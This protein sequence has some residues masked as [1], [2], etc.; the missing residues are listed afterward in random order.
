MFHGPLTEDPPVAG[1][2]AS[3]SAGGRRVVAF[4]T[5]GAAMAG[6]EFNA[7]RLAEHLDRSRWQIVLICPEEGDL[8]D[9]FRRAGL[10]VHVLPRRRMLSSSIR[11]GSHWRIP[12][13]FACAWDIGVIMSAA[14]SL[15][16][17]LANE[18]R[19]ELV[20]TKGMF[21]H[22]YGALAARRCGV[23]CLWHGEDFIS[24]RW[25]GL[26]RRGFGAAARRL[27]AAIAVIG[28]PIARQLPADMQDR[29]RVIHN[30]GDTH[31]FRPGGD[32]MPVRRELGIPTDAVVVG[33]VARL[34]PWKGQR[35]L[36]EA[37]GRLAE[38]VP[39]A[40]LLLVGSPVFDSDTYE[41]SLKARVAELGLGDRVVF[42]GHRRDVARVLAA[43]D[44]LAYP[45]IEKDNCPLSLLEAMATGLPI[46][47]FD[48]P[49]VRLVIDGPD[50][51]LLVPVADVA[52]LADG[53]RR[54]LTDGEQRRRL[55]AGARRR[56]EEAFSLDLH[57]RRFE[58]A[59]HELIGAAPGV[60]AK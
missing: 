26:F 43:M 16:R 10:T 13:P 37:F 14:R 49:G 3:R 54:L 44:V 23:P 6:V 7:I 4:V 9:A 24:E 53:L 20:V 58:Q 60:N 8:T 38:D 35:Y 52:A 31:A 1:G 25:F 57:V 28:E 17:L 56:V 30:G 34:T 11:L 42:A 47:A 59:F 32:G 36:L 15:A 2:A 21:P 5:G 29:V 22:F 19:P 48:I 12:N 33:H 46:I 27:P 50:D 40:R 41:K 51:G 18:V 39:T 45:S 55:G